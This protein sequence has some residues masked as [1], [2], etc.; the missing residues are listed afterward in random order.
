MTSGFE[1][2]TVRLAISGAKRSLKP[3]MNARAKTDSGVVLADTHD[4]ETMPDSKAVQAK[5]AN[6][7]LKIGLSTPV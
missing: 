3:A 1:E 7:I 6:M 5:N 2:G 4:S